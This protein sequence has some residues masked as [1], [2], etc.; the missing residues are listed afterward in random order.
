MKKERIINLGDIAVLVSAVMWGCIGI[1]SRGLRQGGFSSVQIVALR[2]AVT[3]TLLFVFILLVNPRL[4]KI[5]LRDIWMFIGTGLCS[6][7]FFNICYMSS[8]S[9]NSLSVA[10]ILEYTSPIWV[11][12]LSVPL[13]RESF[14]CRKGVSLLFCFAGCVAVCCS[15]AFA[16][17]GKGLVYGL[18]SGF[19]YALYSL[20]GKAA[21]KKYSAL[22]VTFY[23]FFFSALS[24][25]LF[26]R[27]QEIVSMVTV[28]SVLPYALG[29]V[30][31]NTLLP[32][33]LYTWGLSKISAGK[34]SVISM[35]E[36][37]VAALTG[38]VVFNE[39]ITVIGIFGIAAVI[40]GLVL[41]QTEKT[42][43]TE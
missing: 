30:L 15:A 17:T 10:S 42:A 19:G 38:A 1:F 34:A 2:S 29:I 3:S 8:I 16:M 43:E 24:L 14:T 6:F 25:I 4:L 7:T 12:V 23:T 22:T 13:F 36:P 35:L 32:Y 39:R 41:L 20:F 33:L 9:E 26:C 5:R 28:P 31:L 27:P 37:V 11:T 18:L 21:A 40:A